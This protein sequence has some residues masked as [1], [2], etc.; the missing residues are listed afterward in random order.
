MQASFFIAYVVTSGWTSLLSSE[1]FR[2]TPLMKSYFKRV[3]A[4]KSGDEFEVPSIPYH[5]DIP[6][7][8]FF[9][10]LGVTYFFLA[11]LILPFLLV[12]YCMGYI[13]Y[14][15]QVSGMPSFLNIQVILP[16]MSFTHPSSSLIYLAPKKKGSISHRRRKKD[17]QV[18]YVHLSR[19]YPP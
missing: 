8:L 11:P 17:K 3:F 9:G 1:L 5:S 7:I 2:L 10:L 12:Y 6:K 19:C 15:N 14:R 16:L 13:I 4:G 18:F